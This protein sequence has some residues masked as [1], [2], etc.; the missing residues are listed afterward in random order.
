MKVIKNYLYNAAYQLLAI[1]LPLITAPYISRTLKPEGVGIYS[2]TTSLIQWF[3]ILSILGIDLYGQK[4]IASV[5]DNKK[6]LSKA[7]W[8]IQIVKTGF[9]IISIILFILFLRIYKEYSFYMWVQSLN[10]LATLLDI[11]W[12]YMGLENF[13]VTV[14]RN[15]LIKIASLIL[16]FIFIKGPNDV[17]MYIFIT[18]IALVLGNFTLWPYLKNIL[19]RVE[20]KSLNFKKHVVLAL[21]YF[22]PQNAT[23]IY[24]IIN[25][26]LLGYLSGPTLAGFYNNAD[27]L[28]RM[29]L[30]FVTSVGT[31]MMPHIANEYSKGNKEN[32]KKY[33][34]TSFEFVS[35]LSFAMMFGIASISYKGAVFFYGKGY[36]MVGLVLPIE[37]IIIILLGW[38]NTLGTQYL[39]PTN[40]VNQYTQAIVVGTL[41]NFVLDIPLIKVWGL[42]GAMWATVISQI[43]ITLLQFRVVRKEIEFKKIVKGSTKYAVSG[44]MM[45]FVVLFLN[46]K[47]P[48]NAISLILQIIIGAVIYILGLI[49]LKA[50]IIVIVQ[51]KVFNW[52]RESSK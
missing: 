38:S 5:R 31:V 29:V 46:L 7:F 43:F 22:I 18:G 37:S 47:M 36:E 20:W 30:V 3:T 48:G 34:Y 40:R 2:Y 52:K 32:I 44:L 6:E 26:N 25:K 16:I 42:F 51:K 45:Y 35:V 33:T 9:T 27:N 50:N 8:E 28:I 15:T 14:I 17:A 41:I 10:I 12:L 19:T 24:L 11:S 13:R 4:K 49:I 21:A 39:V 23:Q 1:I